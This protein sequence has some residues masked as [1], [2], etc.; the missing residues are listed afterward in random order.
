MYM[1][2]EGTTHE[3]MYVCLYECMYVQYVV[4]MY[5]MYVMYPVHLLILVLDKIHVYLSR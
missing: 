3:C 1:Y 5:V 2:Q 4:C